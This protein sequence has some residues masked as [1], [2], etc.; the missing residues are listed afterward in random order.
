[1][2]YTLTDFTLTCRFPCVI[3]HVRQ[4]LPDGIIKIPFVNFLVENV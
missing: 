4:I 3:F 2:D 1:M